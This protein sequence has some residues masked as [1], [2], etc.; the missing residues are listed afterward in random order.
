[1]S[2]KAPAPMPL[3]DKLRYGA[4]AA[5]FFSFIGLT[6]LLGLH[7][8]SAF[9]G[10]I[11]RNIFYRVT[12][13]MNRAREN[14]RAA[15]PEKSEAE[16]E[17]IVVDMC[18]NLGRTVAEY[19]HLAKFS[20]HGPN[21]R[22]EIV[23]REY[24]QTACDSGKGV[25]FFSGHFANWEMMPFIAR[26]LGFEGGEVYRP[27]N[28]PYIDRWLVAQ[29][30]ANGPA[31]Q[32]AKGVQGTR[33]IFTL[34]RRGKAIFLLTDQKTNEGI[35]A[36]F[37][38]REAMTTPAPAMFALKLGSILLPA[39]NERIDGG[40]RFRMTIYP[41][42]QYTPTGD[43]DRDVHALTCLINEAVEKMVRAKPSMWLWIHRRWPT[44]REQD[45]LR[46]WRGQE[47]KT[48]PA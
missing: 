11:G 37:F 46:D 41:P 35:A 10:W 21:P 25:M 22:L 40:R 16:R 7:A 9:G 38:G 31:D 12:P 30:V 26:Q 19:G 39:V 42:L 4:E 36:P 44:S 17:E 5:A 6:R 13:I 29:R 28:N 18:D 3:G 45:R 48:D 24:G 33:R 27:P 47:L 2:S 15:F 43:Q 1:M 20:M 32:I 23:N 14:L 8:S 34:L